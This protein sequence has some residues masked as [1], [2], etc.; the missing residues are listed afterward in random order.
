VGQFL[1]VHGTDL[2]VDATSDGVGVGLY[3][4]CCGGNKMLV[5]KML[6]NKML[7]NKSAMG[8]ALAI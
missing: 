2:G 5:N 1:D 4:G 6:V 7:V 3:C 8:R